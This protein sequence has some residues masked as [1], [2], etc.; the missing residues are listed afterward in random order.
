MINL[1]KIKPGTMVEY[2]IEGHE[3]AVGSWQGMNERLWIA[4]IDDEIIFLPH[5]VIIKI[6]NP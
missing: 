6:L 2:L 5:V 3:A 4:Q 1:K